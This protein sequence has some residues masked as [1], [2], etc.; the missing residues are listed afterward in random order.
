M[1]YPDELDDPAQLTMEDFVGQSQDID[2]FTRAHDG[3][4]SEVDSIRFALAGRV[5]PEADEE[6]DRCQI[7]LNAQQGIA[8]IPPRPESTIT[9]DIDPVIGVSRSLPD[10]RARSLDDTLALGA[11]CVYMLNACFTGPAEDFGWERLT[12]PQSLEPRRGSNV[13]VSPAGAPGAPSSHAPAGGYAPP[14][15]PPPQGGSGEYR[16]SLINGEVGQSAQSY[17]HTPTITRDIDSVIGVSRSLPYTTALSIWPVPPFRETLT[18]DNHVK[19]R[20]YNA[21]GAQIQVP[22]HRIP[23]VPLGKVEQRHVVRSFFSLD[24][25]PQRLKTL[26]GSDYLKKT[27]L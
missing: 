21:E 8:P 15:G 2:M 24:S 6:V 3:L 14:P 26:P 1:E 13:Y 19:S 10:V 12:V 20:A 22:M 23:N 27:S 18:K 9:R 5:G 16:F 17:S 4:Q 7:R 11:V 25:T